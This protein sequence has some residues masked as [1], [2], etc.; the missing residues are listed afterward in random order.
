MEAG[1]VP[2]G[3]LGCVWGGVLGPSAAPGGGAGRG[4]AVH[5]GSGRGRGPGRGSPVGAGG[6]ASG[7]HPAGTRRARGKR[8]P[9]GNWAGGRWKGSSPAAPR[10][11][12]APG[13]CRPGSPGRGPCRDSDPVGTATWAVPGQ[14][15]F[16]PRATPCFPSPRHWS[17]HFNSQPVSF[18]AQA[19][20]R[21]FRVRVA[22]QE[23]S[24]G[25]SCA[26]EPLVESP[27]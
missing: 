17:M 8:L 7:A 4:P 27:V 6:F 19:G 12:G 3:G 14:E 2:R 13:G 26:H 5:R 10:G 21:R 1:P 23:M 9:G 11:S 22:G 20:T 25:R 15:G 24:Q 16:S 18:W